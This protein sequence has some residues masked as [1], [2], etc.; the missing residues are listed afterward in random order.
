[1]YL[2]SINISLYI[3]TSSDM[4]IIAV[5]SNNYDRYNSECVNCNFICHRIAGETFGHFLK[6]PCKILQSL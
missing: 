3:K 2:L 1:M 6:Y 5:D 4:V